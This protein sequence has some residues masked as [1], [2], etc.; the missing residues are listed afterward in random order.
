[1]KSEGEF[2]Y[3][4]HYDSHENPVKVNFDSKGLWGALLPK[5]GLCCPKQVFVGPV[6]VFEVCNVFF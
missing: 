4:N 3:K 5:A 1:M 6:V 2:E